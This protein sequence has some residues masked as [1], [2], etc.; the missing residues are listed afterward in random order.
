M[1]LRNVLLHTVSVRSVGKVTHASRIHTQGPISLWGRG[2]IVVL[3]DLTDDTGL[4][5]SRKLSIRVVA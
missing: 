4:H 5:M 1:R 3:S 2:K